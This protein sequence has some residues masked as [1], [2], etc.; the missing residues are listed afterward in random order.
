MFQKTVKMVRACVAIFAISTIA[1]CQHTVSPQRPVAQ[2]EPPI[3]PI[4]QVALLVPKGSTD[5]NHDTFARN[6]ENS[7]KLAI[8]DRPGTNLILK[9]YSTLGSAAGAAEAARIAIDD[10]A[11]IIIGPVFSEATEVVARIAERHGI[12]VLSFSNNSTVAGGNVF[13]LGHTH[14]NA[15]DRILKFAEDQGHARVFVVHAQTSAGEISRNA[16]SNAAA[17]SGLAFAGSA[18]YNFTMDD[19]I[20]SARPTAEAILLNQA[21]LIVFAADAAGALPLL[22]QL[23]PEH[24]V[25]PTK[26]KFAG[27]TRW[28]TPPSTLSIKGVQ[29]GWFTLPDPD[30]SLNFSNRYRFAYGVPPHPLA[31]LGYDGIAAVEML[32][33]LDR[34]ADSREV[35]AATS[36]GVFGATGLFRFQTNGIVERALAVAEVTDN[37][38]VIVSPAPA[39]FEDFAF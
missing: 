22:V 7:A 20:A 5:A 13:V 21:D 9:V 26:L 15:A 29:G 14:E 10:G 8:A 19:V 35:A 17:R 11:D 27:L 24:G 16:V 3:E 2:P 34:S 30:R 12:N 25:D 6:L 32:V 18:S 33:G 1:A 38:A 39:Q 36:Q 23:I 28:D 4:R 31:S 37:A